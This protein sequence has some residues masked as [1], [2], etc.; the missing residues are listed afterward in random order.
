MRF[1]QA[2]AE[3]MKCNYAESEDQGTQDG[4][5]GTGKKIASGGEACSDLTM[6]RRAGV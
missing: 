1:A 3:S 4:W 5:Q 6:L 2:R